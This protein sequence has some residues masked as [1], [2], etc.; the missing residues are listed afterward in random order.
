MLRSSEK[1]EI[2]KKLKNLG[3]NGYYG[4]I[5]SKIETTKPEKKVK[6]SRM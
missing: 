1:L 3:Y 6:L 5:I 2:I 4:D